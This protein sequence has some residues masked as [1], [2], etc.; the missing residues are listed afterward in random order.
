M[1]ENYITQDHCRNVATL[2]DMGFEFGDASAFVMHGRKTKGKSTYD[3]T[4][5]PID[6]IAIFEGCSY[7]T[8]G[9]LLHA[10]LNGKAIT[11]K[12]AAL[13]WKEANNG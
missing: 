2:V 11:K 4:I 10:L 12:Q 13:A 8:W 3:I 1:S 9:E 7:L 5:F 6:G